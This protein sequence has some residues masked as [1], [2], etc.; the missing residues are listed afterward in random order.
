[1]PIYEYICQECGTKF[2]SIRSMNEADKPIACEKCNSLE[3]KRALSVC[4]THG[5][6]RSSS[7]Q[8]SCGCGSCSG[9]SCASCHS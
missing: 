7:S 8:S 4:F 5:T 3:T 1:M 2:D 9:G 6:E